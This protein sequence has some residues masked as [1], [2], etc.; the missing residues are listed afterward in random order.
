[1]GHEQACQ[2]H[3]SP[4]L[5]QADAQSHVLLLCLS[6]ALSSVGPATWLFPTGVSVLLATAVLSMC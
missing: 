1:M 6:H 5:P 4:G 2:F 3:P